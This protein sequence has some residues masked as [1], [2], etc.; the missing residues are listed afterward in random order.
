V[1][2]LRDFRRGHDTAHR[3]AFEVFL[4]RVAHGLLG[5]ESMIED[6]FEAAAKESGKANP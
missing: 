1:R 5:I 3:D 2:G 4:C 6:Y